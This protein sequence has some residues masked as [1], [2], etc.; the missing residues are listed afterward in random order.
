MIKED[1]RDR[2]GTK[3]KDLINTKYASETNYDL[4]A[5]Q[6]TIEKKYR[7]EVKTALALMKKNRAVAVGPN[8]FL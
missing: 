5:N 4:K 6:G 1:I 7:R 8:G 2:W 3:L